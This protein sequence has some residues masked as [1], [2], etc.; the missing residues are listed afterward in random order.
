MPSCCSLPHHAPRPACL[1]QSRVEGALLLD[2]TADEA[3]REEAGLTLA[4]MPAS[5][6]ARGL[7]GRPG[8]VAEGG[9]LSRQQAPA[10]CFKPCARRCLRLIGLPPAHP[11]AAG[12]STGQPRPLERGAAAG[13]ARACDGRLRTTGRGGAAGAETGG[14]RGG[15][16]AAAA[17]AAVAANTVDAAVRCPV[18]EQRHYCFATSGDLRVALPAWRGRRQ[19][20]GWRSCDRRVAA[21]AR[22]E[23][24]D[25]PQSTL[26]PSQAAR[27]SLRSAEQPHQRRVRRSGRSPC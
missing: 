27:R 15:S 7:L 18:R 26:L 21:A 11:P 4:I 25:C 10:P 5:N 6:E 12:H 9:W 19:E 16:E 24:R 13:G 20:F 2:P 23:I 22:F 17:A 1:Q 3:A 14:G 8:G